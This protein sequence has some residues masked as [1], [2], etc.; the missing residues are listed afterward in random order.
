[1][2][3]SKR[4]RKGAKEKPPPL[5]QDS[6]TDDSDTDNDEEDEQ[7]NE[8]E[9]EDWTENVKNLNGAQR[10]NIVSQAR[11][12]SRVRNLPFKLRNEDV[13]YGNTH[14]FSSSDLPDVSISIAPHVV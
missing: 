2:R 13:H 7:N 12:S 11:K 9:D 14:V 3:R 10:V 4:T 8:S 1:M 6:D 5:C